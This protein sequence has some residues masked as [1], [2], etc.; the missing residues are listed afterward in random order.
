MELWYK[1]SVRVAEDDEDKV[2]FLGVPPLDFELIIYYNGVM[3]D[4][5]N[6]LFDLIYNDQNQKIIS[7]HANPINRA[8]RKCFSQNEE[9]GMTFEIIRR[10]GLAH[11]SFIEFGVSDG[12][13]NNTL[14]LAA[15]GWKGIWVG[16]ECLCF[17]PN[18]SENF[19]YYKQWISLS[20]LSQL[21][22]SIKKDTGI[23]SPDIFSVDLDGNDIHIIADLLATGIKPK[24]WIAE[25]NARFIPP[26]RFYQAYNDNITWTGTDFFGASICSYIDLFKQYDYKLIATNAVSGSNAFFIHQDYIE[27]FNDVPD[28]INVLYTPP[29]YFLYNNYGFPV[30][31]QTVKTIINR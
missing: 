3:T 27:N 13:E 2:R 9:D 10:L 6:K 7:S 22:A 14:A 12:R 26:I 20:T 18:A 17:T 5:I 11:G 1:W 21:M 23:E 25:Y 28:D 30:D 24:L 31:P 8:G 4:T 19:R 16:N 15:L 29:R